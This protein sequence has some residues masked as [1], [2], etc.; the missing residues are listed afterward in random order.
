MDTKDSLQ[1]VP[2]A[3]SVHEDEKVVEILGA[4]R[5]STNYN[6]NYHGLTLQAVLVFTA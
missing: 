5:V 2:T 6:D 1:Q 3:H 4:E